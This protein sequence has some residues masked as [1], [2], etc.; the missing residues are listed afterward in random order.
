MP[1]FYNFLIVSKQ[2]RTLL[3]LS[4]IAFFVNLGLNVLFVR[5]HGIQGA[6]LIPVFTSLFR[7]AQYL[8][9]CQMRYGL[10]R[11][12]DLFMPLLACLGIVGLHKLTSLVLPLHVDII[13]AVIAYAAIL[14]VLHLLNCRLSRKETR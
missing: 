11:I 7:V 9:V 1:F 10:F 13:V 3:V 2:E 12:L 14:L 6:A 4:F 5:D 8:I